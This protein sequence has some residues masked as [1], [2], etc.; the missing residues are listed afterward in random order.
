MN[1]AVA[2]ADTMKIGE[3]RHRWPNLASVVD[4]IDSE[5]ISRPGLKSRFEV[6]KG[7]WDARRG[8]N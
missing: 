5:A 3:E 6:I 2:I 1:K 4:S 7:P 8:Y